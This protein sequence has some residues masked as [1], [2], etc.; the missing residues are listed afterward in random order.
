MPLFELFGAGVGVAQSSKLAD[1]RPSF[2]VVDLVLI[3]AVGIVADFEAV[4]FDSSISH[5]PII[6]AAITTSPHSPAM[7]KTRVMNSRNVRVEFVTA[8]NLWA[9]VC[10]RERN[11]PSSFFPNLSHM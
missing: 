6:T 8:I 7:N 9:S 2:P 4:A 10:L 11:Y 5:S 1:D 3:E